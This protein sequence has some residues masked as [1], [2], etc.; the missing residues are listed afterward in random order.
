MAATH[1]RLAHFRYRHVQ[2]VS[3][4]AEYGACTCKEQNK[5]GFSIS[6][7][8]LSSCDHWSHPTST[9][10]ADPRLIIQ[11]HCNELML[12]RLT[13]S[14]STRHWT[15]QI[16]I[17]VS[18]HPTHVHICCNAPPSNPLACSR[19]HLILYSSASLPLLPPAAASNSDCINRPSTACPTRI[20][21]T[22][23]LCSTCIASDVSSA[24]VSCTLAVPATPACPTHA[25]CVAAVVVACPPA[26]ACTAST[27]W[28]DRMSGGDE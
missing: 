10:P 11:Q 21:V 3:T 14:V 25:T 24:R 27:A 5:Y 18:H 16:H 28:Y 22:S 17:P 8:S 1:V 20:N 12:S 4:E 15:H 2:V 7:R 9:T 6:C 13:L 26:R 23:P 19:R